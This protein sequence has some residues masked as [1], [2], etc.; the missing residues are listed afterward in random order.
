MSGARSRAGSWLDRGFLIAGAALFAWL[1]W[2]LGAAAVWANVARVG[3]G[4]VPLLAQEILA[5]LAN[6]AGWRAAFRRPRPA[7]P[8]AR[9]LEARIA[10]DAVNYLTPTAGL[11]GEVVRARLLRGWAPAQALAVSVSVAKVTQFAGQVLYL[12]VG[13]ALVLPHTSLEP[14]TRNAVLAGLALLVAAMAALIAMQRRGLF[15][16]LLAAIRRLGFVRDHPGLAGQLARLD[17]EIAAFHRHDTAAFAAS[18][19]AFALGWALGLVEMALLLWFLGIE[20]T[21]WQLLAIEVLAIAFDAALFFV[22]A[23]AGTQEAGKVLVFTLL[24][25]DPAQGL[26]V[27]ILR[28]VRELAW[29]G[30]GM[31]LLWRRNRAG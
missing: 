30:F 25:L 31:A 26:A 12:V 17:A 1:V 18:T 24:G 22:P 15:G 21:W 28:R 20:V 16:P 6:T 2:Q 7:I 9:L 23:K 10:G 11:G 3:W 14:G 13:L 29:A 19:L 27:G 4:I 8:A 5:F